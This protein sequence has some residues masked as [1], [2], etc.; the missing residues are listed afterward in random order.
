MSA[1]KI[2]KDMN[3]EEVVESFPDTIKPLQ[4]MGVQCIVCG[5]PVWGTLEDSI[6]RKGLHNMDEIIAILNDVIANGYTDEIN[7]RIQGVVDANFR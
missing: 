1:K 5:E 7:N 6:L 3:M 2:A 4:E